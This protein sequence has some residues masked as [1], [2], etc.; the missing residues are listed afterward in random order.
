MSISAIANIC[1]LSLGCELGKPDLTANPGIPGNA[2]GRSRVHGASG[3]PSPG[4][5]AISA[6]FRKERG[7]PEELG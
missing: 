1:M 5:S 7:V 6:I 2:L 3:A 4:L